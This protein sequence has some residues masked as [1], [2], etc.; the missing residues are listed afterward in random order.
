MFLG[1][2][3]HSRSGCLSPSRCINGYSDFNAGGG[4]GGGNPA[5]D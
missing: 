4:G 2:T 1:K 5:I 3:R